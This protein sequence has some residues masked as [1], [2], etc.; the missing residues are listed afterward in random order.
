MT[1]RLWI[2]YLVVAAVVGA[3]FMVQAYANIHS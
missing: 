2:I 1:L 3:C